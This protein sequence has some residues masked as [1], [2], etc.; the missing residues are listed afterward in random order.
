MG[1]GVGRVG[2]PAPIMALSALVIRR[3]AAGSDH[4]IAID[5]EGVVYAWG[6][7]TRGETGT[8]VA[9]PVVEQPTQVVF[10][11]FIS[12]RERVVGVSA[13]DHSLAWTEMGALYAWGRNEVRVCLFHAVPFHDSVF[14]RA[15]AW[16]TGSTKATRIRRSPFEACT[17]FGW[18]APAG[19]IAP[20]FAKPGR[21][22]LL[23]RATNERSGE[24]I[25]CR[26][27]FHY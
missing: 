11:G 21:S 12:A 26:V 24:E 9:L 27:Y 4:S 6:K 1:R 25:A 23:G 13:R 7:N 5:D 8:R 17:T 3:V 20:S 10:E 16:E 18:R 15:G 14:R 22:T 19:F 2:L